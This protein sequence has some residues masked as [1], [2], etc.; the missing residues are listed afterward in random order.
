VIYLVFNEGY[1][2]TEG[3]L[4][5]ADLCAEAIRLARLLR[6]LIPDEGETDG[7]LALMLLQHARREARTDA[8]GDLVVLEDQDRARWDHAMIDEGLALLR[9]EHDAPGPY[10]LQ[11]EIAAC[12]AGAP[13]PEDTDWPRIASLYG[14]LAAIRPSPVVELNRA[15][16]V[17]MADGPDAGL[18]LLEPLASDLDRYH[19]FHAAHADLLRRAGRDA[20]A[21]AAYDRALGLVGNAAERRYL[22]GRRDAL[23]V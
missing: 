3:E 10:R 4:L 12:H 23:V 16:A 2:A 5:R 14:R 21:A 6:H 17:A 20:E 8:A 1:E 18:R 22:Q 19:L 15:A 11:A 7:L 13:R 9:P